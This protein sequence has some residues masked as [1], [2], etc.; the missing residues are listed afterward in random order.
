MGFV[1]QLHEQLGQL[2][3]TGAVFLKR[4]VLTRIQKRHTAARRISQAQAHVVELA[5]H[6]AKHLVRIA[7]A[8]S[9]AHSGR[10]R[11]VGVERCEKAA[12]A[13]AHFGQMSRER[14]KGA[15]HPVGFLARREAAE[16]GLHAARGRPQRVG[17]ERTHREAERLGGNALEVV[18]FV[19]NQGAVVA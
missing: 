11:Q 13:V 2:Q 18:G 6:A 7:V 14:R 19:E 1:T 9:R 3:N 5:T 12:D 4:N 15:T 16:L 8:L 17:L 10:H